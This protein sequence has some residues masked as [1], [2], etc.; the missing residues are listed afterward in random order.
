MRIFAMS[1]MGN[2]GKMI[3]I[4]VHSVHTPRNAAT[5]AR[6]WYPDTAGIDDIVYVY[7]SPDCVL[8]DEGD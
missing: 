5:K 6:T 2:A 8:P 4:L 1:I 7:Q 3:Q